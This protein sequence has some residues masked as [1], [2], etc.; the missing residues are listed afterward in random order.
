MIE[1]D[2]RDKQYW[3]MRG[4]SFPGYRGGDEF[5]AKVLETIRNHGVDFSGAHVL[6]LGCGAGAYAVPFAQ[7]AGMVT[8]LDISGVMLERLRNSAEELGITNIN[9]VECDW[10]EYEAKEKFD[11]IFCSRSP[12]LKD[13]A[14]LRKACK[15]LSGWGI[16]FHFS[17]KTRA[18]DTHSLKRALLDLH[19]LERG[20]NKNY[21]VLQ[22]WLR[23]EGIS[24]TVYPLKGERRLYY[25]LDEMTTNACEMVEAAG[26]VP[27][28]R[29]I[30]EFI[31]QFRDE[32]SGKYLSITRYDMELVIWRGQAPLCSLNQF[33]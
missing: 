14:A 9:Y 23:D 6:D 30:R 24:F 21:G 26:A 22:D 33:F 28:M 1:Y 2:M 4:R 20:G 16:L 18:S 32:A 31:E 19:G 15:A 5:R 3:D 29:I 27:D 17:G 13:P 25:T 7:M 12:A 10:A 8:A 11:I